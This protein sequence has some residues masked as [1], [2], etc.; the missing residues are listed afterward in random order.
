MPDFL[1]VFPYTRAKFSFLYLNIFI[2]WK[3]YW[4]VTRYAIMPSVLLCGQVYILFS[5][6]D[7][8]EIN[9]SFHLCPTD[10][11]LFNRFS[12]SFIGWTLIYKCLLFRFTWFVNRVYNISSYIIRLNYCIA[13]NSTSQ[14]YLIH[15]NNSAPP[16]ARIH[17]YMPQCSRLLIGLS[18]SCSR[19]LLITS[20]MFGIRD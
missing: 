1:N 9:F 20:W 15:C 7:I 10:C 16:N 8:F 17:T 12:N 5:L 11:S 14:N 19:Y 3:A 6:P 2:K 18:W 4:I 13:H